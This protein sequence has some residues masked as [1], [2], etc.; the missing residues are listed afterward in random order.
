M[1]RGGLLQA[2]RTSPE[3]AL[4]RRYYTKH[5]AISKVR[6][7]RLEHSCTRHL[8]SHPSVFLFS[9][10]GK[11]F[12]EDV[13]QLAFLNINSRQRIGEL[14]SV[15]VEG[16][17]AE[18][19]KGTPARTCHRHRRFCLLNGCVLNEWFPLQ[20]KASHIPATEVNWSCHCM[21]ILNRK[22]A[23][24]FQPCFLFNSNEAKTMPGFQSPPSEK[25]RLIRYW[26]VEEFK[27]LGVLF[28]SE[29]SMEQ[30]SNRRIV[31]VAA[32]S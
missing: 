26:G 12:T 7:V 13:D 31:R 15:F 32:V 8:V 5:S 1:A 29:G 14:K 16:T 28:T 25:G 27:Y 23:N 9:G 3:K 19:H 21:L 4:Q 24:P 30:E 22:D 6:F 2:F 20:Q 11:G 17:D 18:H 10:G